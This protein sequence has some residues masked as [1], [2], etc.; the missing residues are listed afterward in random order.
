MKNLYQKALSLAVAAV[1]LSCLPCPVTAGATPAVPATFQVVPVEKNVAGMSYGDWSAAWWQY[2]LE[3]PT[4]DNPAAD[5]E[6]DKCGFQQQDGPAF[7]LVGAFTSESVTRSC[8]VPAGKILVVPIL[9]TECSTVEGEG[10]FGANEKELRICAGKSGDGI[11][12]S[13]LKLLVDKKRVPNLYKHR[14]QSPVFSFT[15]PA[16]NILGIADPAKLTGLAV[17]DGYWAIIP[18]LPAGNHT[19]HFEGTVGTFSLDITYELEIYKP[20]EAAAGTVKVARK[21]Q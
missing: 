17:S 7:F 15:L 21:A 12:V 13:S 9:N 4:G 10:Y 18:P 11:N 14:V 6:G 1:L 3:I 8:R 5:N 2:V 19:V 20:A 16:D